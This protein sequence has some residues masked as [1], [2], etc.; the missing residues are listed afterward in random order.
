MGFL[1][2]LY[3]LALAGLAVPIILHLR[4]RPPKDI[5]DFP[6]L[7]FLKPSPEE[8]RTK[9]KL[10][11]WLL[12]LLRCLALALLALAF[13][14]PFFGG[15]DEDNESNNQ[16]RNLVVLLDRSASM[17]RDTLW[18]QA[19]ETLDEVVSD[20]KPADQLTVI[21]FGDS[22]ELLMTAEQWRALAEADRAP[23]LKRRIDQLKP[24]WG[25]TDLGGALLDAVGIA[26]L[27]P[28]E[29]GSEEDPRG[30]RGEVVLISDLQ[31]GADLAAL[32]GLGWPES[33]ELVLKPVLA[34][35]STGN[36]TVLAMP[37]A[38]DGTIRVLVRNAPNSATETFGLSW[39]GNTTRREVSQKPDVD[40]YVPAGMSRVVT[41]PPAPAGAAALTLSGDDEPFDNTTYLA[42]IRP[43]PVRIFAAG[44]AKTI[45]D[46]EHPNYYVKRAF[47]PS[48]T[49]LPEVISGLPSESDAGNGL[50]V[51]ADPSI[52]IATLEPFLTAGGTALVVAGNG[53]AEFLGNH[54][55]QV[56]P[57]TWADTG[58]RDYTLLAD[59]D[60]E[61]PLL[62]PFSGA[63]LRN[64]GKIRTWRYRGLSIASPSSSETGAPDRPRII[65][66]FEDGRPAWIDVPVGRG[67]AIVF[68]SSWAPD[69]SQLA[70]STKF[71]PLLFGV[72]GSGGIDAR[73]GLR[74]SSGE[75]IPIPAD[76]SG[77]L[78][79]PNGDS[80]AISIESPTAIRDPEL[81]RTDSPGLYQFAPNATSDAA[82]QPQI[83]A[84]NLARSEGQTLPMT[85]DQL[86]IHGLIDAE[87]SKFSAAN[88]ALSTN[89][90]LAEEESPDRPG[91]IVEAQQ[92][93]WRWWILAALAF[94]LLETWWSNRQL[95]RVTEPA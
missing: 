66:N 38:D 18:E 34:E 94:L 55:V 8:K 84:V 5:K 85:E 11:D 67:R 12:L 7:M 21:P 17:R 9:R 72:L 16:L 57:E 65:A 95:P 51:V 19:T 29:P 39:G 3:L 42:P 6:S 33:V 58:G 47:L 70:L 30:W 35:S 32:R 60:F 89:P 2:P 86:V 78:L 45:N 43:R 48:P 31:K 80:L 90:E 49:L 75:T 4:R 28:T 36:A 62:A 91:I 92:R 61:H 44:E 37:A 22:A 41:L 77:T 59:L 53:S 10:D 68:A 88:P 71:V 73:A 54:G 24:G 13:A 26:Q 64:F 40:I 52:D 20:L 81:L 63:R 25:G 82:K 27:S 74:L 23:E 76:V 87:V 79:R 15:G 1:T 93:S 14:R 50:A 69:D 56:D 46:P 83:Y